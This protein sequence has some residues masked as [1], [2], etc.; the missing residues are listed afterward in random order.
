MTLILLTSE[1]RKKKNIDNLICPC[2]ARRE[3]DHFSAE[4]G[5]ST[6]VRLFQWVLSSKLTDLTADRGAVPGR[7]RRL[8]ISELRCWGGKHCQFQGFGGSLKFYISTFPR[9]KKPCWS[10]WGISIF[11]P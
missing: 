11:W 7:K 2:R 3:S 1:V 8:M 6:A 5:G 9:G 10:P 4:V